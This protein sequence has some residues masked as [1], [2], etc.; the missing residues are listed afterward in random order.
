MESTFV[1]TIFI[2]LGLVLILAGAN[3]LTDGSA[4]IARRLRVSEFI[5]GLTVV[6][7]G[8]SMPEIVVSAVSSLKG[9][10]DLAIGNVNGSNIFNTLVVLGLS[11]VITPLAL[12]PLNI[13]RDIPFGIFAS[14]VLVAVLWGGTISRI[15][16]AAMIVLYLL[17][18]WYSIKNSRP[19]KEEQEVIDQIDDEP[20][21]A[22]WLAL[23]M[24]A[25][26]LAAL[27]GGGNML[28]NN[29]VILAMK[30]NIPDNVIAVTLL[31][32]GTSLPELAASLISLI[33][34]KADIAL[35]NVIGSNIANIFLALGISS[36]VSPLIMGGG[37]IDVWIT[38]I[39]SVL[40]LF[41]AFTFKRKMLDRVEGV[42]FLLI[43]VGYIAYI[44]K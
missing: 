29:A 22:L 24:I 34:G 39:S 15:E 11:A 28:I 5:I 18:M 7:L 27:I 31:A 42:I 17:I 2:T 4:A 43:Y 13:R 38:L 20:Q 21:M 40:L 26:G 25:G 19:S 6:A 32:G 3:Y 1:L 23:V 37:W 44:I 9:S 10:A 33:K 30:Y 12:T 8:T 41:T 36:T 16:G 14:L 35:G